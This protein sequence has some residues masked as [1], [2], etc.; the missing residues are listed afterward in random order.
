MQTARNEKSIKNKNFLW[1][2]EGNK[3]EKRKN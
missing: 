3:T 1:R 2:K